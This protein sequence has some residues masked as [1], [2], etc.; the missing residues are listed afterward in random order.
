M[1]ATVVS[2]AREAWQLRISVVT[3]RQD[4]LTLQLDPIPPG[5]FRKIFRI[6]PR[7]SLNVS[8]D[9]SWIRDR[10]IQYDGGNM[11]VEDLNDLLS[12]YNG[13][14]TLG[15]DLGIVWVS[16]LD[17]IQALAD[18]SLMDIMDRLGLEGC[19]AEPSVMTYTYDRGQLSGE[20]KVPSALDAIDHPSFRPAAPGS[21]TGLTQPLSGGMNGLHEAVHRAC[22]IGQ[23]L[24][25]AKGIA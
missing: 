7:S 13:A 17:E 3:L 22:V 12:G 11:T 15:N 23:F 4:E 19:I 21:G 1:K 6:A 8:L 5:V 14:L 10:G 24:M 25:E 2:N 18:L 9:Q 20:L 16:D